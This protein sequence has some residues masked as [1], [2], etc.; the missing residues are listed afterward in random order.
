M[1]KDTFGIILARLMKAIHVELADKAVDL[2][3][4]EVFGQDYFLEL[5]DVL[6]D[7]VL[8]S[9]SPEYNFSVFLILNNKCYTFNI[10]NVLAT[11]PATS[12]S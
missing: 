1:A 2:F 7:K 4:A 8:A 5:V 12:G 9:R 6:D 10:Q 3:V 11:N